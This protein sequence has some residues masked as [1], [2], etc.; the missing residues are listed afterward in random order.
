MAAKP[1]INLP[2]Q[3]ST[4][5]V[6]RQESQFPDYS[7]TAYILV[8]LISLLLL[9][10]WGKMLFIPLFLAFLT[11]I[12]L[13]PLTRFFERKRMNKIVAAATSVVLFFLLL[14]IVTYF[15]SSEFAQFSKALPDIKLKLD[16]T[17]KQARDWV[18]QNFHI[19]N[20]ANPGFIDSSLNQLMSHAGNTVA[21]ILEGLISIALYL[22]FTF[23]I[24]YHRRLLENFMLSFFKEPVRKKMSEITLD[25][26]LLINGYVKGLLIEMLIFIG[27]SFLLLMILGLKYALLMAIFAGVLNLV[28]YLGIYTAIVINAMITFSEGGVTKAIEMA[29]VF[30]FIHVIDANVILPRVVG[31]SVKM[32]AF[33]TLIAVVAGNLLWGI[34]GMFLFIPLAAIL[35][36]IGEKTKELRSWAILIG[37]D[38][39]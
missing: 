33:V 35:R 38:N 32:N 26:R 31:G 11:A 6:S 19:A 39:S 30:I 27:S 12:F 9:L 29:A 24:L 14:V 18:S 37:E 23:Y 20:T 28:P 4:M 36:V 5:P 25:L 8:I 2:H 10:Y 13:Y 16:E 7:R 17:I 3:S 34:P 22:F 15:F 1:L 21:V